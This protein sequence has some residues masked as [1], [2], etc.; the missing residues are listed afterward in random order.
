MRSKF[1]TPLGKPT[2]RIGLLLLL[3]FWMIGPVAVVGQTTFGNI[4]GVV[5]DT[6]GAVV[7][8]AAVTISNEG[9]NF[10]YKTTTSP[11]GV[12]I[13]PNLLPGSYRIRIED[14]GFQSYVTTGVHLNADQTANI[15]AQLA[16]ASANVTSVEVKDTESV[17]NTQTETL[18]TVLVPSELQELPVITRQKGDE[19]VYGYAIFNP[20]V[21][22]EEGSGYSI[23]ANG[24]RYADQQSTVDG[25]TV[26]SLIDGVGGSTVQPG[27][28]AVGEV[29]VMLSNVP[30]Q[31][32]QPVQIAMVRKAGTNNFHGAVFENYNGSGFNARNYFSTTVPFRVYNDFGVAVGGPIRKNK[33]FFFGD[34]EGSRESTA[35]IDTLNVP[36]QQWQTGNFNDISTVVKNPYTGLPYQGNQIPAS[37]I[38]SVAQKI[39]SLYFLDPNYGPPTLQ[40]GNYRNLFKPGNNGVTIYNRFDTRVDYNLSSR[41][42]VYGGFS[43]NRMPINAYVSPVV[44][45]FSFRTSLRVE[46]AGIAAWTHTFNS[47]LLNEARFGFARDNN[48]IK[49]PVIGSSILNEVGITGVPTVGFPTYPV[50]NV[51]GLTSPYV[52]PYDSGITTN[53]EAT[54]NVTW[55]HKSH[56]VKFG[57]DL[58]R[59][60]NSTFDYAG[61]VYGTYN[62]TG[63]FTGSPYADFLLGLPQS[64]ALSAPSP[65]PHWFGDW[66]SAYAQ[67]QWRASSNLTLNFGLRWEG[68]EPYSEQSGLIYNFDPVTGSLVVPANGL[69]HVNPL[70]P[71]YIPIS[72]AQQ[73]G[74][75]SKNLLDKH[76]A[77]FYP[78]IGIAYRPFGSEKTVVR[79][80]YGIYSV[81]MYGAAAQLLS[82]GPFSGSESFTNKFV[83]G[84]PLFSFPQPFLASGSIASQSVNGINPHLKDAYVQQWNLTVERRVADFDFGASYVGAKTTNLAYL[85]NLNQPV[86]S[87]T[88]FSTSAL[89]YP[90]Y[91]SIT[92]ADS[93]AT[94][95]YNALQLFAKR[96]YG[97]NLILNSGFTWAKDLTDAQGD[98]GVF[99]G[100]EI[101]NAYNLSAEYGNSK[102]YPGKDFFAQVLYT[103]PIG[104]G[105]AL[106]GNLGRIA[107]LFVGGWKTAWT[108]DV[109]SGFYFTP[110]LSGY[111]TSNT[112]TLTE[113]P[114]VVPGVSPYAQNKSI[115][116]WLN[117]AAFKIPGCPDT[118]P[119]CSNPAD[120]GRFGDAGVNTLVGPG[121]TDVDLSVFKTFRVWENVNAKFNATATDLFNHPNFG[122]P[123]ATITSPGTYGVIT[124]TGG[125]LYGQASRFLDF[126]FRMEF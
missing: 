73:A 29:D 15:D 28:E 83:N 98:S 56:L 43:Y 5:K 81:P 114:D 107:D 36:L 30:A 8:G 39:Q 70:F 126:G 14:P 115:S 47:N 42:M 40:A 75:P 118:A 27:L 54:D 89:P 57:F 17:L 101:Q 124:S 80:G 19:G 2:Q 59:D 64:T 111:D 21:S 91:F 92:W 100:S 45:P 3:L 121:M 84:S 110:S 105:Q 99:G 109:H 18:S 116:H 125:D 51:T 11:S 106:F 79:G 93:G 4:T 94:E 104:Q 66:W 68:Q 46:S 90:N 62:F 58:I 32:S 10:S 52:V 60:R 72:T 82:G 48:Q 67:D 22:D 63:A 41:D 33:L 50:F 49:T 108:V 95:N 26:M 78:R 12:Y 103:L 119:V 120:V 102:V 77:Y 87:T 44:P 53:F 97:K 117:P 55:V 6:A 24:S 85:R 113:R 122:L 69:A 65:I 23:V 123:A 16:V 20:G 35:V 74:Y 25:V 76:F 86:P 112:N 38:S 13:Q 37:Q 96:P 34:Y 88:P 1:C 61:T 31:F 71:S 9:T 7:S